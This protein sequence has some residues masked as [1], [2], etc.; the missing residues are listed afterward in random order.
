M[1]LPMFYI[2]LK[3]MLK[4]GYLSM[5]K[6]IGN[7]VQHGRLPNP[8]EVRS[9]L[10]LSPEALVDRPVYLE[11]PKCHGDYDSEYLLLIH[12]EQQHHVDTNVQVFVKTV[13]YMNPMVV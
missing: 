8:E 1:L 3:T 2:M 6:K 7:V 12:W 11:C 5:E 10:D 13:Y 4:L 9:L